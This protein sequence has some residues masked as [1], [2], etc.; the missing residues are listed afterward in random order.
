MLRMENAQLRVELDKN[1]NKLYRQLDKQNIS[2]IEQNE[3]LVL[4]VET[5]QTNFIIIF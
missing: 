1:I 3:R 2:A 4:K 5:I